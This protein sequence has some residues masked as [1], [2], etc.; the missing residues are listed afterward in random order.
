MTTE[1]DVEQYLID[2]A[3][4]RGGTAIKFTGMRGMPDRLVLLPGGRIAFVEVKRPGKR[5]S[6]LQGYWLRVFERYGFLTTTVSK[7]SEVDTLMRAFFV[8][9]GD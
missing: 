8:S 2:E 6:K 9:I 3:E 5:A 7:P 4:K 1:R